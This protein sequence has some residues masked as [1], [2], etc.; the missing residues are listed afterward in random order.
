MASKV[1]SDARFEGLIF[2]CIIVTSLS[3]GIQTYSLPDNATTVLVYLE[4]IILAMF[5]LEVV[6]KIF[7]KG[8]KPWRYFIGDPHHHVGSR[9]KKLTWARRIRRIKHSRDWGSAGW[10]VFDFLIVLFSLLPLDLNIAQMRLLRLLRMGKIVKEL[11][12]LHMIIVGLVGGLQAMVYII[13]LLFIVFYVYA[14][15][16]TLWFKENDP[17]HMGTLPQTLLTLW[18]AATLE[19]WTDLMYLNAY[20]CD[21]YEDVYVLPAAA[22]AL[23]PAVCAS[24][25]ARWYLSPLFFVSF[26]VVASFVLLSLFIGAITLSMTESFELED[27]R[28]E[29][30]AH[31]RR[32]ERQRK[33]IEY[34]EN[35]KSLRFITK[36]LKEQQA[37]EEGASE[38]AAAAA[39]A[40]HGGAGLGPELAAPAHRPGHRREPADAGAARGEPGGHGGAEHDPHLHARRLLR[41]P[42]DLGPKPDDGIF[43]APFAYSEELLHFVP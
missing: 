28:R 22:T 14:C 40:R 37:G 13:L 35:M 10:N 25:A 11:P 24:P 3:M 7:A 9:K 27:A 21:V 20:G 43:E 8:K 31:R 5:T 18:R 36:K 15:A 1:V 41:H 33:R 32:L 23:T 19:D 17:W 6:L 26:V 39:R 4:A 38:G 42:G 34:Q 2:S 16:G 12:E 30:K 29:Q